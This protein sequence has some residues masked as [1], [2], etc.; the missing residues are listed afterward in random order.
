MTNR[1]IIIG[2]DTSNYTTSVALIYEDGEL[3][4]NIKQP[5]PVAS[6]E[7]GLRQSDAL[8]AHIKNIPIVMQE[9]RRHLN[10]RRPSAIGV[11]ATP[12]NQSGS[13]MPVFLAGLAVAEA[14]SATLSVP[15]YSF[16][17]QCGHI[18]SALYSSGRMDLVGKSFA[19]FHVS[20][21]T[22]ELVRVSADIH[23]FSTELVGGTLD[24]NA[25]QAIDRIGVKLGMPFPAGPHMERI[26]QNYKGKIPRKRISGDGLHI[27]LSGLEN[28]AA[29]LYEDTGDAAAVA[30]FTFDYIARA[31]ASMADAYIERY[32]SAPMI[33][34]GGVM[35]NSIIKGLLAERYDAYF[36]E[37]ML[38]A[39]NAVGIALLARNSYLK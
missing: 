10:G 21:G 18:M 36:A 38:S 14:I 33:F 8:F 9:V 23:A 25:G 35:S 6:G 12:R 17:H 39:D 1:E 37:P 26:A 16:S 28:M 31:L 5:L 30:A 2:I 22:T 32:G 7:C 3:M 4:A 34:A 13:Y 29:K 20:G 15:I 19:A 27:N 24:L 11:S